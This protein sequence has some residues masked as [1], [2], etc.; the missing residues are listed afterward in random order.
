MFTKKS[1]LIFSIL[2]LL[3]VLFCSCG[4][5]IVEPKWI[6]GVEGT[7]AAVFSSFDYAKLSEVIMTVKKEQQDGSIL[8]ETWEGV[9]LKDV[10]DYL[11]VAEYTSVTLS[12]SDDYEI[13][14]SPDIIND[15]LTILATNVNGRDIKHED[16]YVQVVAGN[17]QE[18]MWIKQISKIS[19]NK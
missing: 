5:V 11:G 13:E 2:L 3:T 1:I 17:Q 19:V 14:Y 10:L 18:N 9:Y 4:D 8:E 16:G 15:S 7:D 12:S 6:I